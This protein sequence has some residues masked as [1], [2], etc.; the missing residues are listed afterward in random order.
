MLKT[1]H[2]R[3][4]FNMGIPIPGKGSLYIETGPWSQWD[5]HYKYQP[6]VGLVQQSLIYTFFSTKAWHYSDIIMGMMASQ[7]TS[8][9]IVYS[10]VY[11]G[12]DERKHQSSASLAFVRRIHLSPVNSPYKGPVMQKKIPFDDVIIKM[13]KSPCWLMHHPCYTVHLMMTNANDSGNDKIR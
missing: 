9:T 8:L 3:L 11:S 1:R 2:D 4:I 13:V 12:A 6:Y 7:I 10:T 5:A